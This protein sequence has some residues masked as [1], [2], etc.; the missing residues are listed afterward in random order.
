MLSMVPISSSSHGGV[1]QS[2]MYSGAFKRSDAEVVARFRAQVTRSFLY[3][4]PPSAAGMFDAQQIV[5]RIWLG[6]VRA[7]FD[8][9]GLEANEIQFALTVADGMVEFVQSPSTPGEP[10]SMIDNSLGGATASAPGES[11]FAEHAVV[12]INDAPSE[13]ILDHLEDALTFLDDCLAKPAGAV[14]VH[15]AAGV[16][17]SVSVVVA[18]LITRRKMKLEDALDKVKALRPIAFPNRGFMQQLAEL[19]RQ[20]GDIA[21]AREAFKARC[22]LDPSVYMLMDIM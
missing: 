9:P 1:P 3:W 19:D 10:S 6:S 12:A 17:R 16:S 13:S 11:W 20:G 8:R 14:L 18:Y 15:C 22:K 5:E 2:S 7:A 4:V 21:K